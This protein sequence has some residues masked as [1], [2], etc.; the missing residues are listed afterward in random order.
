MRR[1]P[2]EV[3]PLYR[4]TRSHIAK[5]STLCIHRCENVRSDK[6][7]I[8][9]FGLHSKIGPRIEIRIREIRGK[10]IPELN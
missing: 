1:I 8:H 7:G 3:H 6:L 4:T 2:Q 10:F 5:G 9:N